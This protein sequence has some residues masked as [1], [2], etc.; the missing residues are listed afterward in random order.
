MK[1]RRIDLD[2]AGSPMALVG[3]ILK[4]EPDLR[5]PIPLEE[6][7]RQLDIEAIENLETEGFEGGL[8]TDEN[9]RSGIILVNQEARAGR[10]RFTIGHELGHFLI[11]SH[12]PVKPGQFL[13][14]R[15]D[16][17]RWSAKENDRYGQ[18]EFEANQFAALL[19]MPPP[20]LRAHLNGKDP[21]L[22][23]VER[24]A[25]DFGV[26]KDAAA[27]SYATHHHERIAIVVVKDGQVARYYRNPRFPYISAPLHKPVPAHT[28]FYRRGLK[29]RTASEITETIPDNW[30]DVTRGKRAPTLYEQVYIQSNGFA[31][32]ML[33]VEEEAEHDGEEDRDDDRTAKQRLE[34]RLSR[35]RSY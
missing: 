24:I 22:N 30:I 27:R 23:D 16:M 12:T 7:T 3:R 5:P 4:I 33:W 26:S 19:L 32:I 31:L 21:D 25:V 9:R 29:T 8:L 14:S 34:D 13:C 6:L 18:M 20:L 17:S 11:V 35:S 15:R 28:A 1:I 10:R 2:G